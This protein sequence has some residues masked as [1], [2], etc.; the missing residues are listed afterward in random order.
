M[1]VLNWWWYNWH[2]LFISQNLLPKSKS[3]STSLENGAKAFLMS[4]LIEFRTLR[5]IWMIM[6][7]LNMLTCFGIER[8]QEEDFFPCLKKNW[9]SFNSYNINGMY[10]HKMESEVFWTS[11]CCKVNV[12]GKWLQ[13]CTCLAQVK[14]AQP[15]I[16]HKVSSNSQHLQW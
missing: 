5:F 9:L 2:S 14:N 12:S 15:W 4:N 3:K 11:L 1:D 16:F 10:A 7:T 8:H 6:H 13:T